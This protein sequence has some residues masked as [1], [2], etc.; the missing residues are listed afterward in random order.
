MRIAQMER[1]MIVGG[2]GS[3]KSKLGQRL[4]QRT[5]LPVVHMDHIHWLPNWVERSRDDKDRMT[6]EVH[7]R[8][9]WILEGGHSS[10][11]ADRLA[12]ADTLIWLDVGVWRRLWRVTRRLAQNYGKR[13]PDMAEGCVERFS[14]ETIDF[15]RFIWR[16]RHTARR[17]CH[18]MAQ[19]A[20][21]GTRVVVLRTFA[22]V[23]R[24]LQD[25]PERRAYA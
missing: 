16:T 24:F 13:R 12:H 19:G 9:E 21:A 15:Y 7:R 10:T 5:G 22:D 14:M 18:E 1:V 4:G 11:Y 8:P 23:D 25:Q 17:K 20:P 6:R 2:P 3:G